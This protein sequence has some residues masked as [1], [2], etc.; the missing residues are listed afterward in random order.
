MRR[1]LICS[2]ALSSRSHFTKLTTIHSFSAPRKNK[3]WHHT[4]PPTPRGVICSAMR[5]P[6][7]SNTIIRGLQKHKTFFARVVFLL[8]LLLHVQYYY[9]L[10][11]RWIDGMWR[12]YFLGRRKVVVPHL[13]KW[14][15]YIIIYSFLIFFHSKFLFFSLFST[16]DCIV[17]D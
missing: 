2:L 4:S 11:N 7:N 13:E 6:N 8:P 10:K 17:V 5:H 15:K 14:N 16:K 3:S 12:G 1:S 9:S